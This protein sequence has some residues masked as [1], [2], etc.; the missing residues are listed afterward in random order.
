MSDAQKDKL[1]AMYKE[2]FKRIADAAGLPEPD[3]TTDIVNAVESMRARIA[4]LEAGIQLRSLPDRSIHYC[5]ADDLRL[6]DD[7]AGSIRKH[8]T[9]QDD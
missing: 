1:L 5:A 4:E 8:F 7:L 3:S 2:S 9:K 6:G